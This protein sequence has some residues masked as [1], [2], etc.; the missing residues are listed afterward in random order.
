MTTV[1]VPRIK[2]G[3]S[4]RAANVLFFFFTVKP[5]LQPQFYKIHRHTQT[6]YQLTEGSIYQE[7][8]IKVF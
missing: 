5:F 1:G 6:D 4:K 2:P 3:S 7:H 8:G